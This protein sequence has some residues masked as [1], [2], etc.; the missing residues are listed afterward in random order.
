MMLALSVVAGVSLIAGRSCEVREAIKPAHAQE[1]PAAIGVPQ[2]GYPELIW[3]GPD[4]SELRI[5]FNGSK[6]HAIAK[7]PP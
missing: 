3:R 5:N 2:G 1:A 6:F 4:G 7:D